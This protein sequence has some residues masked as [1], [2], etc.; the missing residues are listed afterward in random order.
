MLIALQ[1]RMLN[2]KSSILAYAGRN[3]AVNSIP[4][5]KP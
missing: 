1:K 3:A 4:K 2:R 5:I